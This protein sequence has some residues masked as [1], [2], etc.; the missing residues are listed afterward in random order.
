MKVLQ[1]AH[2]ESFIASLGFRRNEIVK[3]ENRKTSINQDPSG[4]PAR[5]K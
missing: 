3:D 5:R 4:T 2:Y 1:L